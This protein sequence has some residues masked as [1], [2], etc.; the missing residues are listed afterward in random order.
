MCRKMINSK[1]KPPSKRESIPFVRRKSKTWLFLRTRCDTKHFVMRP[2]KKKKN[3]ATLAFSRENRES[4]PFSLF[5]FPG[6]TEPLSS[7]KIIG[8]EY[9]IVRVSSPA[10]MVKR[11]AHDRGSRWVRLNNHYLLFHKSLLV[12]QKYYNI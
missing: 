11:K 7:K 2:D 8:S 4:V 10:A 5:L 12:V 1:N 6:K 9:Q 3:R